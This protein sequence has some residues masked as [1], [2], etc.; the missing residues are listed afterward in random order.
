MKL[1]NIRKLF[2]PDPGFI[3]CDCDLD[4][5]DL[6]VVIAEADDDEL[7]QACAA[8]IDLHAENAAVLKCPRPMAK[9]FVHGTNY[10]GS[11][12]TMAINC[13]ISTARS[14]MMQERWFAQHP[15]IKDWHDRVRESLMTTRTVRNRFGFRRFYFD[16]IES[17]IPEALAWIPQSTVANVINHGYLNLYNDVPEVQVLM[18]VHDSLV[19]QVRAEDFVRSL[20]RI[21]KALEIPIPYDPT[22]TIGVGLKASRSSW[23]EC[24]D[25]PWDFEGVLAA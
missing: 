4:R 20:P 13:G 8:G 1:P 11:A 6:Q 16:R 24:K 2:T 12:R 3:I 21:R 10:G 18:Q 7:R 15:G 5:A 23:G 19:F 22:L 9:A 25:V 17:V 14:E